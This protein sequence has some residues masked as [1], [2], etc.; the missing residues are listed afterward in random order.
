MQAYRFRLQQ[1]TS[2]PRTAGGGSSW[3]RGEYPTPTA[4][5]YGSSNNGTRDGTE[6]YATRGNPS[7]GSW[8][9]EWP[10][11]TA[12][13]SK[14]GL[15]DASKKRQGGPTLSNVVGQSWPTPLASPSGNRTTKPRP[16]EQANRKGRTLSGAA[17]S[18]WATP[19]ATDPRRSGY[20]ERSRQQLAEGEATERH[21]G[22]TL[23]DMAV[24]GHGHPPP[25]ISTDGSATS[26][27]ADLNPRFVVALM[28]FPR[29]WL[30][31]SGPSGSQP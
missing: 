21:M 25:E 5:Q 24:R 14:R 31:T 15:R 22:T 6:E 3:S 8:A 1:R 9:K 20:G 2:G 29:D 12:A 23:T 26:Q 27:K 30:E 28:G 19:T 10:T 4:S 18:S 7:L 16:S 11:A 17:I 13:D